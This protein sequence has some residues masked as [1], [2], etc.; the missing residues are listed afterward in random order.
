LCGGAGTGGFPLSWKRLPHSVCMLTFDFQPYLSA[1]ARHYAQWWELYTLTDAESQQ[2]P[3]LVQPFFDF[4]LMVQTI[5]PQS[6]DSVGARIP[7]PDRPDPQAKTEKLEVLTGLRKYAA[8]HVLLVGRPGSGKSTALARLMLEMAVGDGVCE[9]VGD[10]HNQGRGM[11][12]PTVPVLVELRSWQTSIV[13]LIRNGLK[14]HGLGLSIAQVQ[15]LVDDGQF[16]LLIDGVNELPSE[17]ARTDVTNFRRN[18]SH[19]PM[20]FTT[21]DLSLGGDLG[22]G[23]RLEMK[24]LSE[25]Q[26]REFVGKYLGEQ[27]EAIQ[28][29]L[30]ESSSTISLL[31]LTS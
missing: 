18:H 17:A 16:L 15:A 21:R 11:R 13:D 19:I 28:G 6:D 7:R 22:I 24:P 1:I 8:E 20:I 25:P 23:K 26:L 3:A 14:R 2:Q 12:A 27:S 5:V 30:R 9:A 10:R 31:Q 4:G 29:P